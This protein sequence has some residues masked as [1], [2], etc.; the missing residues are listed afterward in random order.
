MFAKLSRRTAGA[1]THRRRARRQKIAHTRQPRFENLETRRM[2]DGGLAGTIDLVVSNPPYIRE[3]DF[4]SLPPEV[5]LHEPY[6]ALVAGPDGTEVQLRLVQEAGR[7]LAPGGWLMM[8]GSG[9][10]METLCEHAAASGY[11]E[12]NVLKDLND[13]PRVVEMR[14][15]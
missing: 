5:R 1:C 11:T 14:S 3:R 13:V 6:Q 2:L 9:D 4:S 10:Q 12:I 7:W 15:H 8:G